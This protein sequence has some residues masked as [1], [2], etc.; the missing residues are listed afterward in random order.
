MTDKLSK[1]LETV[2]RYVRENDATYVWRNFKTYLSKN[3]YDQWAISYHSEHY[4]ISRKILAKGV[5]HRT[6]GCEV[7]IKTWKQTNKIIQPLD[8]M[9]AYTELSNIFDNLKY[10]KMV[11]GL[12]S[13]DFCDLGIQSTELFGYEGVD[14]CVVCSELTPT[15]TECEHPLCLECWGKL[16]ELKC[17]MCRRNAPFISKPCD[18]CNA[19]DDDD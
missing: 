4:R 6:C 3:F 7:V 15:K 17:P 19:S 9:E 12:T 2:M 16:N 1:F 11:E 8:V 18:I 14:E 10:C 5:R 13:I